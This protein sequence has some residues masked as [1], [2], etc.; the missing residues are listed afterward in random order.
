MQR[1]SIPRPAGAG[2]PADP[3][4]LDPPLACDNLDDPD[5]DTLSES[6]PLLLDPSSSWLRRPETTLFG[7]F[8]KMDRG[9]PPTMDDPLV[10]VLALPDT[11]V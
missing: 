2:A 5:D 3:A 1:G 4:I 7:P 11:F 10:A 6:L 9:L 8:F